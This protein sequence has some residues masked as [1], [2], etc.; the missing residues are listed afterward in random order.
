VIGFSNGSI[1]RYDYVKSMR[2]HISDPKPELNVTEIEQIERSII[3]S[4]YS[5]G[6]LSEYDLRVPESHS[7]NI[8]EM[9]AI[10]GL[11]V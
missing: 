5:N 4:G 2:T 10:A 7:F 3:V 11:C 6:L 9:S 1:A 8:H